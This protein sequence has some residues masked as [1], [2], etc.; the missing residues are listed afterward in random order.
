MSATMVRQGARVQFEQSEMRL[1]MNMPTMAKEGFSRATIVETKYLI[2]KP[3]AE[4]REE[5]KRGVEFPGHKEMKAAIQR[6]LA[7]LH[8]TKR[9]AAFLAKMAPQRI[10]RHAGDA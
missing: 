6:H 8:Q 4:V 2:K 9:P 1:A 5:R 3:R 10:R 7:M